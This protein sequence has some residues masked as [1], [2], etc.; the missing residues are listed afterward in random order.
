MFFFLGGR[1]LFV[2]PLFVDLFDVFQSKRHENY[3]GI[4]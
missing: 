2:I 4:D 3:F 1:R